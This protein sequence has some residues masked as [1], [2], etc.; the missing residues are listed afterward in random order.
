MK[1]KDLRFFAIIRDEEKLL[2]YVRQR[3]SADPSYRYN[4]NDIV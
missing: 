4:P 2:S 1:R 3:N